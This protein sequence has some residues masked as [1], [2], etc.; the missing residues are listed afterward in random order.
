[1]NPAAAEGGGINISSTAVA[2]DIVVAMMDM[3][4]V[5]F[6]SQS[7]RLGFNN[8]RLDVDVGSLPKSQL[9]EH[10]DEAN[11]HS[12]IDTV[13]I[14]FSHLDK[15]MSPY[16]GTNCCIPPFHLRQNDSGRY[17]SPKTRETTTGRPLY[18]YANF[19]M[20]I[21]RVSRPVLCVGCYCFSYRI[22]ACSEG[23][24]AIRLKA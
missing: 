9:T 1:M 13:G 16:R 15:I 23:L 14:Q 19:C 10:H 18:L 6:R 11:E 17:T 8:P 12:K 21:G 7:V 4:M 22:Y 5:M 3:P 20:F 24:L 2:V